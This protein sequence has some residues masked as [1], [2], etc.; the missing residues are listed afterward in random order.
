MGSS[1]GYFFVMDMVKVA[2][3]YFWDPILRAIIPGRRAAIKAKKLAREEAERTFMEEFGFANGGDGPAMTG[4]HGPDDLKKP[5]DAVKPVEVVLSVSEPYMSRVS[6]AK[7]ISRASMDKSRQS[8]VRASMDRSRQSKDAAGAVR[9][10]I[11]SVRMVV[12]G[13]MGPAEQHIGPSIGRQSIDIANDHM[14]RGS[15][16]P[17][18]SLEVSRFD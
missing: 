8:F 16:G 12:S 10:S 17:R 1:L 18:K 4:H 15:Q 13:M 3:Y 11:D 2:V 9:R 7:D 6:I 14:A 5:T